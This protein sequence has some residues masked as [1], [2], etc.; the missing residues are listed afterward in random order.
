MEVS[1]FIEIFKQADLSGK[2]KKSPKKAVKSKSVSPKSATPKNGHLKTKA[3]L[4]KRNLKRKIKSN[5]RQVLVANKNC[6]KRKGQ[7]SEQSVLMFACKNSKSNCDHTTDTL[8]STP[9][10]IEHAGAQEGDSN[11]LNVEGHSDSCGV[12]SNSGVGSCNSASCSGSTR[13]S[14]TSDVCLPFKVKFSW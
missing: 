13:D 4:R 8:L 9:T 3:T 1:K 2:N 6:K 11:C 7:S 14:S 12:N 5:D 10:A